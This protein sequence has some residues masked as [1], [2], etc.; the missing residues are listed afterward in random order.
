MLDGGQ[1]AGH[2]WQAIAFHMTAIMQGSAAQGAS[3]ALAVLKDRYAEGELT[4]EQ[5]ERMRRDIA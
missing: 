2:S 4:S 5:Y 1:E 3:D